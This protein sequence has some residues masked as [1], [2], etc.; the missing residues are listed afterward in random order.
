MSVQL[1]FRIVKRERR[2]P[3]TAVR[4]IATSLLL[5]FGA[6]ALVFLAV[7]TNPLYALWKIFAGSFGSAYGLGETLTKAIPLLIIGAGLCLPYQGRFWN[8][9]AESQ[10]LMGALAGTMVGLG[11]LSGVPG[12]LVI[13]AMFLIAFAGGAVWGV[14]PALLK[15]RMGVNEVISTLML[16][17]VALEFIQF[18]VVGPLK[19]K[20]QHGFPYTDD[21]P[22][23]AWL[24]LVP[25]TRIHWITLALGLAACAVLFLVLKKSKFGYEVRVI[26][27]NP[28]AARYA[29]IGFMKTSVIMM[30]V[31]GGLAGLAGMGEVAALHHHLGYPSTISAGYGFTAII[32]AW[33]ARLNPLGVILSSFFFAGILVGG[34]A[35]QIS[36]KLPAA[37]VN[38]FNGILLVFLIAGDYFL[39]HRIERVRPQV[40]VEAK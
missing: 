16:N 19:G 29:G 4:V 26:G 30:A 18:L 38:V 15:I 40:A 2:G 21:L 3:L 35:I 11:F 8:I 1:P 28:E 14:I 25:G 17:Y 23:Q 7:G 6:I 20:S 37:T 22:R 27:E 32:V 13:P 31:S 12:P 39:G 34:D 10:L 5:G 33:L 9:G 24:P 36:L